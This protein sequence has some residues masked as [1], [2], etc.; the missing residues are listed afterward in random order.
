MVTASCL[1]D[2]V[3]A[4]SVT[5]L[6]LY[7]LRLARRQG[8]SIALDNAAQKLHDASDGLKIQHFVAVA[9]TKLR[10]REVI[11]EFRAAL[12]SAKVYVYDNSST[13]HT[14][15]ISEAAGAT[16]RLE[17]RRGGNVV[18]RMFADVNAD[19]FILVD[20]DGTYD[21]AAAPA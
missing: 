15:A 19:V 9:T 12:P 18:R 17:A 3:R 11:G 14:A 2:T 20:R 1:T 4:H 6:A 16:V 5:L 7:K 10:L 21:A 8:K 13:D